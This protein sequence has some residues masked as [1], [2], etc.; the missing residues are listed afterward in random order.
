MGTTHNASEN[1]GVSHTPSSRLLLGNLGTTFVRNALCANTVARR[2]RRQDTFVKEVYRLQQRLEPRRS[3]RA[4]AEC[5]GRVPAGDTARRAHCTD[6]E[7]T[8]GIAD[9][10]ALEQIEPA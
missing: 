8:R 9:V 10:G 1:K 6:A 4:L 7:R 3:G 2:E 5:D